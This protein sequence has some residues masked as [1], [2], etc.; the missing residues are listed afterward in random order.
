[1][2]F[3]QTPPTGGIPFRQT[4][5]DVDLRNATISATEHERESAYSATH[6]HLC[7]QWQQINESHNGNSQPDSPIARPKKTIERHACGITAHARTRGSLLGAKIGGRVR[8]SRA[9]NRAHMVDENAATPEYG[10][11]GR[12]LIRE[13]CRA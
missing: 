4:Q 12:P 2:F 10:S 13:Q 3:Q 6:P 1:M 7:P 5:I 9:H 8:V 11:M